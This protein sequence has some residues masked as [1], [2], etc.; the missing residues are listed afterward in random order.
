MTERGLLFVFS[1]PSGVGK[2]TVLKKFLQVNS[3]CALSV[4]ATTREPREG[5]VDGKDYFFITKE[6][7]GELVSK[8]EMLEYAEYSGNYYGTPKAM[9]EEQLNAGKNVIL[10]I[11]AKGAV[12]IREMNLGSF[13]I[14]LMPPSWQ[15][16]CDRLTGRG[17]NSPESIAERLSIAKTEIESAHLYNYVVVNDDLDECVADM[18]LVISAAKHCADYHKNFIEE[19]LKDAETIDVPNN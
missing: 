8:G 7:F 15:I 11:E 10:E 3:D 4:S 2:D 16:L 5:E 6:K 13:S 14:F 12:K 19:V 9:V 17:T 18:K 1:G